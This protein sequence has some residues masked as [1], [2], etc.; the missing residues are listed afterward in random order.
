MIYR[1]LRIT[2]V[3]FLREMLYEALVCEGHGKLV[4]AIWTRTLPASSPGYGFIDEHTP[5]LSMAVKADL[6]GK[7]QVQTLSW[8]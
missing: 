7:E 1:K 6:E 5:E 3:E 4:A 2:E 8:N